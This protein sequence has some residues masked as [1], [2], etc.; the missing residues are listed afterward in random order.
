[1]AKVLMTITVNCKLS[2]LVYLGIWLQVKVSTQAFYSSKST[3]LKTSIKVKE[4][5]GKNAIRDKAAP[6]GPSALPPP[7]KKKKKILKAIMLY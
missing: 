5:K 7:Q 4:F 1:M 6:Q 2:T 3:G